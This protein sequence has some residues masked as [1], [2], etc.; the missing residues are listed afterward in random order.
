MCFASENKHQKRI[1]PFRSVRRALGFLRSPGREKYALLIA[2]GSGISA[3]Q[4]LVGPRKDVHEVK[5]LLIGT[6]GYRDENIVV[7]TDRPDTSEDMQPTYANIIRE[8]KCFVKDES[9]NNDYFFY[10]AGHS[11]Q[12][13]SK[14]NKEEDKM[15]EFIMASDVYKNQQGG[16]PYGNCILDD[17]LKEYLVAPL[18]PE[19]HFVAIFDSCHSGTLLDLHHYRCNRVYAATSFYRRSMRW[20]LEFSRRR[21]QHLYSLLPSTP[22]C[23]SSA[24]KVHCDGL[25]TR[26]KWRHNIM[27]ISACRDYQE[28]YEDVDGRSMT[29]LIIEL[30]KKEPRPTLKKLMRETTSAFHTL[31]K[32]MRKRHPDHVSG[33]LPEPEISSPIPLDM[34]KP[35]Y[36]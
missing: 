35:F 14:D 17:D 24:T 25:C 32:E 28:T 33:P 8:L 7:L 30:L 5:N 31:M 6:Y 36:L 2:I 3:G 22:S 18:L 26:T 27:C 34:K 16:T 23:H 9:R 12:Q 13:A 1:H 10:Y 21:R 15:D 11:S 29:T 19:N 20:I 4:E